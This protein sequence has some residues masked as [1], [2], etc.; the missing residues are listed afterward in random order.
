MGIGDNLDRS[1]V[2]IQVLLHSLLHFDDSLLEVL[3]VL[4]EPLHLLHCEPEKLLNAHSIEVLPAK[5]CHD[6]LQHRGFFIVVPGH[7]TEKRVA[8]VGLVLDCVGTSPWAT[9]SGQ[10]SL[11][12][13]TFELHVFDDILFHGLGIL[14]ESQG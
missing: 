10:V 1:G 7:L 14:C 11:D 13:V 12:Q 4:L 8:L 9:L 6:L 3:L 5:L 2:V